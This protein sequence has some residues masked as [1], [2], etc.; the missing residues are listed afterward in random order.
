MTDVRMPDGTIV[1]NVP[2]G[3]TQTELLRMLGQEPQAPD[4]SSRG[5]A[6]ARGAVRGAVP[7][8]TG[9]GGAVAG[10][11]LGAGLGA[12]GGPLA[13]ITVPAGGLL[14]GIA[15]G[16]LG[17]Y[18]GAAV[19]EYGLSKLPEGVKRFLG[20]DEAQRAADVEEHPYFSLAGEIAP[21]ALVMGPGAVGGTVRAGASALER[22][23]AH[24][25]TS[26]VL[27]AGLGAGTQAGM[28]YAQTGEIDLGNV[29][30][31]GV[32]GGL[33]NK[34]TALGRGIANPV[35]QVFRG[36]S[37]EAPPQQGF[38]QDLH[39]A[40]TQQVGQPAPAVH[41]PPEPPPVASDQVPGTGENNITTVQR[42]MQEAQVVVPGSEAAPGAVP[43]GPLSVIAERLKPIAASS[44]AGKSFADEVMA[45]IESGTF[46]PNQSYFAIQH[47]GPA[48]QRVLGGTD[49]ALTVKLLPELI[50]PQG[51]LAQGRYD[52]TKALIE[53]SLHPQALEFASE[54]GGHEAFHFLQQAF[55]KADPKGYKALGTVFRDGMTLEEV[56]N[57]IKKR[58]ENTAYPIQPEGAEKPL[59]YW[60]QLVKGQGGEDVPFPSRSEAEAHIFGAIDSMRNHG[61]EMSGLSAP[62]VRFAKFLGD[63]KTR[64]KNGFEGAGFQTP[65]DVLN[66]Y[67]AGKAGNPEVGKVYAPV[68]PG[69]DQEPQYS[70]RMH[71]DISGPEKGEA[72]FFSPT[73]RVVHEIPAT[74]MS[75]D[76]WLNKLQSNLG[77][78][79]ASDWKGELEYMKVPE[80]LA[81][82][83]NV[84]KEEL[85]AYIQPKVPRIDRDI[86]TEGLA[87]HPELTLSQ[88]SHY[89]EHIYDL[90]E[91]IEQGDFR[92][93]FNPST[94][95]HTRTEDFPFGRLISENQS[96]AHQQAARRRTERIA[97]EI[98][99]Q[100]DPAKY[101]ELAKLK[102]YGGPTTIAKEVQ[103]LRIEDPEIAK[104]YKELDKKTPYS[105][106]G[107]YKPEEAKRLKKASDNADTAKEK[108]YVDLASE[109]SKLTS[110]PEY[111][112][113][114]TSAN[115]LLNGIA[116]G[117]VKVED[118]PVPV[119]EKI[120]EYM[121]ASEVAALARAEISEY[122]AGA[123]KRTPEIPFRKNWNLLAVKDQLQQAALLGKEYVYLPKTAKQVAKIEE[124]GRVEE[125]DG[126]YVI[127]PHGKDVT[128]IVKRAI[129]NTPREVD[130][131]LK[132]NGYE[133]IKD[134]EVETS[135]GISKLKLVD[136]QGRRV[137]EFD[138]NSAGYSDAD[139][140]A[141]NHSKETGQNYS[142][143]NIE[144]TMTGTPK[145]EI[146]QAIKVNPQMAAEMPLWS[147]RKTDF[148]G[149]TPLNPQ[150]AFSRR[151]A[152]A[153]VANIP[154]LEQ[155]MNE[156]FAPI[157]P[158][159]SMLDRIKNMTQAHKGTALE[160]LYTKT[161]DESYPFSKLDKAFREK[162][163]KQL[164][165]G[166]DVI[167]RSTGDDL[168]FELSS[169]KMRAMV[170][171]SA[172]HAGTDMF[173][174]PFAL[175][176]DGN[177]T[178]SQLK[179]DGSISKPKVQKGKHQGREING[180]M[181]IWA[182]AYDAGVGEAFHFYM[183]AKR[184]LRLYG[185]GRENLFKPGDKVL[186]D[187][188]EQKFDGTGDLPNFKDM[189]EMTHEFNRIKLDGLVKAGVLTR[190]AAEHYL[191]TGD[192]TPFYRDYLEQGVGGKVFIEGVNTGESVIHRKL[193]G[194]EE[195][196][197]DPLERWYRHLQALDH[198]MLSN[199]SAAR[200]MDQAM[201]V[202]VARVAK[203]GDQDNLVTVR[204]NGDKIKYVV[205]DPLLYESL[206]S[207]D[208]RPLDMMQQI[209]RIP[210]NILRTLT[211]H[212][213]TFVLMNAA[214]DSFT[215]FVT[216]D[217]KPLIPI[218]DAVR[219]VTNAL[220]GTASAHAIAN[221][222]ILG[223]YDYMPSGQKTK[224]DRVRIM[225]ARKLGIQTEE[226][227]GMKALMEKVWGKYNAF[228][229]AGE[230]GVRTRIYDIE[231]ANHGKP[232]EAA[233][234]AGMKG[235][236]FQR[237]GSSPMMSYAF[238]AIPFLNARIQG[239]DLI[240]RTVIN[241][242]KHKGVAGMVFNR[243]MALAAMTAAYYMW[244]K[245][246]DV[247]QKASS[248]Y[249]D[250]Y[251]IVPMNLFG[252]EDSKEAFVMPIPFEAGV[253]YKNTPEH[254][255]RYF[256]G[257]DKSED[258]Q[259]SVMTSVFNTLKINPIPQTFL[260]AVEAAANYSFYT[261]RAIVPEGLKMPGA[262]KFEIN[263][264][265][266]LL[267]RKAGAAMNY[268]P[269]KIDHMVRGYFG[270]VGEWVTEASD[271][272][273][274]G[275]GVLPPLPDQFFDNPMASTT[276]LLKR[277]MRSSRRMGN[278]ELERL[279][280][281]HGATQG[282]VRSINRMQGA[283]D[284]E[285]IKDLV[286]EN[287]G[288]YAVKDIVNGLFAQ[289]S[290]LNKM[291][292]N[293][294]AKPDMD[295][296]EKERLISMIEDR[297]TA[298][299]RQVEK[300]R[301]IRNERDK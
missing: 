296:R 80:F 263:P 223:N 206:S 31:A 7:G 227:S 158:K 286:A 105:Q 182:P 90:P 251:W 297:K 36:P 203:P 295:G 12:L 49:N 276:P 169:Y 77:R 211:T 74:E 94:M 104:L 241:Q 283:G 55:H 29:G 108:T 192:Y 32:A 168:A 144:A 175:T 93:H 117:H 13:P 66:A 60:D 58:L 54:T 207:V 247:Y 85:L 95:M 107:G 129:Q 28:D 30:I 174:A 40:L 87:E 27:G 4:Q 148:D 252:M 162:Y 293:I 235:V 73:E 103:R 260:P 24:P 197:A 238:A 226:I 253:L 89:A 213:P 10:A 46:D 222:G 217:G 125:K 237:R 281:L 209:F 246:N 22:V 153:K 198:A 270:T 187:Q 249:K 61:M 294:Q 172:A 277:F 15:G 287:K 221:H 161:I 142:D 114:P 50:T 170:N 126:R 298:L 134:M 120:N 82:K 204:R 157:N 256:F 138:D 239:T 180:L 135:Q 189:A 63:F 127:A 257:D 300:L 290:Q 205:D 152:A 173:V 69:Q 234:Q 262:E 268:S 232:A 265:T 99:N 116:S 37:L 185:E 230:A 218:I 19:Q 194:G 284:V 177:F 255:L 72:G 52:P 88:N 6:L 216:G 75:G 258:L 146:L 59:T 26:R 71:G 165:P 220:R 179:P 184:G 139:D 176:Q 83:E 86:R 195:K 102:E 70:V 131:W 62:T 301:D 188:L 110:D 51:D 288:T 143:Y 242:A 240:F 92:Q 47:I 2:D 16:L 229:E 78:Y 261:G 41:V 34:P 200:A 214:R 84:T 271:V 274:R 48:L 21:Q 9:F 119:Q 224:G 225:A 106:D 147:N 98:M 65:E 14:G 154:G 112:Q 56:P 245:D 39:T 250:G 243:G 79:K 123:N 291:Q 273:G 254:M 76:K 68:A 35:H 267:A 42:K 219:G 278:E 196:L 8:V 171:R 228:L 299:S 285:G 45:G 289:V 190:P 280:D 3:I 132:A 122:T 236:N 199:E 231:M 121:R 97:K 137:G 128:S 181:Q 130:Q 272:A 124:W 23:A 101:P 150:V 266:S 155:R 167:E 164:K 111:S 18:G 275:V 20:Q 133:T 186:A 43:E 191:S 1:T 141:W 96:D 183:D 38:D 81:G 156:V 25:A 212:V 202:G 282:L 149:E 292:M 67:S 57:P 160:K 5:G 136:P 145:T 166:I 11:E 100:A 118:L 248:V 201:D 17:G 159:L 163:A 208:G 33:L 269:I 279:Y 53:F 151:A 215:G 233:Y 178:T 140:I 44:K 115:R 109:Y 113:L 193:K 91:V 64:M 210:T 264:H 244:V 259:R